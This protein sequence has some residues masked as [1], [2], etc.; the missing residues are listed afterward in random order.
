MRHAKAEKFSTDSRDFSRKLSNK[1]TA[2]A[3]QI[4]YILA[5]ENLVLEQI[6]SSGAQRTT[7]TTEILSH[8]LNFKA[9]NFD[10][11]LYLVDKLTL[12]KKIGHAKKSANLLLVGHNFGISDLV[13]HL[14]GENITLSTGMFVEISFNFDD[15]K[16][17]SNSTGTIERVLIPD[18]KSF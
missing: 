17:I 18:V 5:K 9:I 14:T 12:L 4:G 3:N 2:Q 16:L 7:E 11:G 8:Y 1:G 15:W 10:D 6:I 13:H